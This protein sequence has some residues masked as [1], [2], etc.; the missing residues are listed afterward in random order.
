MIGSSFLNVLMMTRCQFTL[1]LG[2]H[3]DQIDDHTNVHSV[4]DLG[5]WP[6]LGECAI[7][8]PPIVKVALP[9]LD[10]KRDSNERPSR[11]L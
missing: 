8:K 9:N 2:Q 3:P 5:P 1:A 10:P 4:S 7:K 6:F 11:Y